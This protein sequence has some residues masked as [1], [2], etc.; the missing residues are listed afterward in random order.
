MVDYGGIE[1][2]SSGKLVWMM[3]PDRT[4]HA[5]GGG[6]NR[7]V[8]EQIALPAGTYRL[9]FRT[10]GAH[11]FN[12]WL[13]LPPDTLF[14]GIALYAV[15]EAADIT[16]RII[17]ASPQDKLLAAQVPPTVPPVSKLEY[18]ILWTCLGILLSALVVIPV[19]LWRIK[20]PAGTTQIARR[21]T[22]VAAWVAWFNSL[23]CPLLTIVLMMIVD[24]ETIVLE[25]IV[26]TSTSG[27][28]GR[29]FAGVSYVCILLAIFQVIFTILAWKGK[30]RSLLERLYY[31]FV[32]LAAAGYLLLMA[33]LGLIT[34]PF[35]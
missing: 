30:Q 33:S 21:W 12:N 28:Q 31:S 29:I 15:G 27:M 13:D 10:D 19:V 26:I 17:T 7:H 32:T 1:D 24:L 11:S 9:H 35:I 34:L 5:G 18:A 4:S 8:S 3:T 22:K 6:R 20:S 25:P 2:M 16:T 23:L 14:W